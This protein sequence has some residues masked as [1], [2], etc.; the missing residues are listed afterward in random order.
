MK[1][2]LIPGL[3]SLLTFGAITSPIT[4][5][6]Y[7]I[8]KGNKDILYGLEHEI[9]SLNG[10]PYLWLTVKPRA[11]SARISEYSGRT[12]VTDENRELV[13]SYGLDW[14]EKGEPGVIMTSKP[15]CKPCKALKPA[16]DELTE[17]YKSSKINFVYL[18]SEDKKIFR[19]FED[20]L[21]WP[22]IFIVN[23]N[24]VGAKLNAIGKICKDRNVDNKDLVQAAVKGY[25]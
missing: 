25:F 22:H 20:K 10:K 2:R 13:E 4:Y 9:E 23:N 14:I 8:F 16:F 12:I 5:D 6:G 18:Y 3:I 1:K 11:L 7:Q 19:V 17:D 15:H 21:A 24:K